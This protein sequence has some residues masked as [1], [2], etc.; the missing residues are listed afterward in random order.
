[1]NYE[2]L[3]HTSRQIIKDDV[4]ADDLFHSVVEQMLSKPNKIDK[5][6]DK[7]KMYYFVRIVK[8]N[9]YSNTSPFHYKIRRH[10]QNNEVWEDK[11]DEI[12]DTEYNDD[13]PSMEWVKN[14][15][16]Q[17]DWFSRDLFLLWMELGTLTK[18]SKQTT[19]PINSV[20][21]Y[22]NKIKQELQ[23]KWYETKIR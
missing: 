5:L 15:L 14:Q 10:N 2:L 18:V 19:I 16:I 1:M 9:Y 20:G 7:E 17:M 3:S 13:L 12:P 22:I 6:S 11:Y 4:Y 21:G 23:K 8:N